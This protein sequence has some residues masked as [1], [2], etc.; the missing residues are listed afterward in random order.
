VN[1]SWRASSKRKIKKA[2]VKPQGEEVKQA[3]ASQVSKQA[4]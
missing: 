1:G 2:K 3:V 4:V